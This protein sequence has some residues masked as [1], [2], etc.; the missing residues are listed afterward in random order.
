M[1]LCSMNENN[2]LFFFYYFFYQNK[3]YYFYK[4]EL[5]IEKIYIYKYNIEFPFNNK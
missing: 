3:F 4:K 2:F 5:K 1:N